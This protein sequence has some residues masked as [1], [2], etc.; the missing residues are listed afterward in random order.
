MLRD[1]EAVR[2]SAATLT[3]VTGALLR[4]GSCAVTGAIESPDA[5]GQAAFYTGLGPWLGWQIERGAL[6]MP[7]AHADVLATHLAHG[8]ARA[9]RLHA[10]ATE[11][12]TAF[13]NVGVTAVVLKGAHL[14]HTLF[15][16]PGTRPAQDVDLLVSPADRHVAEHV[17]T[18][19]GFRA[20]PV[21][22]SGR[23]EWTAPGGAAAQSRDFTHADAPWGIDLHTGL[24]RRYARAL[25]LTP[26]RIDP[27][28]APLELL[29]AL[30]ARVLPTPLALVYQAAHLAG[31]LPHLLPLRL[32]EL[33]LLLRKGVG[34]SPAE[35]QALRAHVLAARAE[36][37]VY[38]GLALAQRLAPGCVDADAL[39]EWG[40]RVPPA[41]RRVT[42]TLPLD[43][44]VGDSRARRAALTMMWIGDARDLMR[45]V[46]R[47]L[48][49]G[50]ATAGG[51]A[52]FYARRLRFVT[53]GGERRAALPVGH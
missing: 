43:G 7:R 19:L 34:T 23:R 39:A 4:D 17:L 32:L 24:E 12:L 21:R 49:P 53:R 37:L 14:A 52:A 42:A 3:R 22:T 5:T 33:V 25:R 31:H 50:D 51:F 6:E 28:D 10:G 30:T 2:R 26:G 36:R 44:L 47:Q 35:W 8:R 38:P 41:M 9:A 20:E 1:A 18:T 27:I 48:W 13:A 46:A 15:P 45:V 29:G 16:E 40:T 11:V